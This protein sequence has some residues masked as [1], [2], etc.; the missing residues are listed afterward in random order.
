M[1]HPPVHS[2]ISCYLP[3]VRRSD[4]ILAY[5]GVIERYKTF[6]NKQLHYIHSTEKSR[7]NRRREDEGKDKGK[8]SEFLEILWF[9]S[10]KTEAF[11][12]F[13]TVV[14]G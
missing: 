8:K 10:S 1:V 12:K 7:N 3:V 6:S 14:S 13:I 4:L 9:I 5:V 11:R 2:K